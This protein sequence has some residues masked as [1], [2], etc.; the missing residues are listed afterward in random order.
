MYK[1]FW[2]WNF[3]KEER[4]LNEMAEKGLA[5]TSVGYCRYTFEPCEPGEY[6]VRL[7]LLDNLPT[8]AQS[9]QYIRFVESTG[10]EHIDSLFRWIYFRK[11]SSL[12]AFDLYSDFDCRI[13]H[14]NRI[15]VLIAGITP[16]MIVNALRFLLEYYEGW[17]DVFHLAVGLFFAAF[18]AT[19]VY[20]VVRVSLMKRRLKQEHRLY[21]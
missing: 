9:E 2:I 11:K 5:L 19:A 12:G 6:T 18:S 14:L 4:W 7:E 13:R 21:E 15:L 8:N 1:W 20:G 16:L 3:D 17:P 10:A